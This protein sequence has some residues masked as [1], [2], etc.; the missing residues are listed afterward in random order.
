MQAKDVK[1]TAYYD[2]TDDTNRS[3]IEHHEY[4]GQGDVATTYVSSSSGIESLGDEIAEL[5]IKFDA[6]IMD[7]NLASKVDES[8]TSCAPVSRNSEW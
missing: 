7:R 2:E 5:T 8:Q 3:T 6:G 4:P 1:D